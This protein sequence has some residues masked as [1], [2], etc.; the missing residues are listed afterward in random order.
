MTSSSSARLRLAAGVGLLA[1][2]GAAGFVPLVG[3]A[4]ASDEDTAVGAVLSDIVLQASQACVVAGTIPTLDPD[5]AS[6]ADQIVSASFAASGENIQVAR[7]ALMVAWTESTLHDLGPMQGNDG[8]LGLFQQRGW[9]SPQ[10]EMDPA[11]STGLFVQRLLDFSGWPQLPSWVAAQDV[12]RSRF[13]DGR[14][15]RANWA[16]AGQL[17]ERVLAAG[18]QPGSCGQ[19]VPVGATATASAHGLP[20]GYAIP[21]DTGLAHARVV[22]W[23][24]AQLSKPY[25]WGAAGPGAFDCSGLTMA[26]WATVGVPLVHYTATQQAEGVAIAAD[27]L[28]PGDLVLIPGSD[29]PGPGQAGHVGIYLGLGLVESAVDPE[30]GVVVQTWQTFISGGLIALRDPDPADG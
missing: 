21:A 14:N 25:V 3:G 28:M 16:L 20:D 7:I 8:S 11:V 26:A 24:L 15:Y 10:Q 5:Q 29:P 23:A 13:A 6:N 2:L 22:A 18:N 12:Q 4:V 27:Q 19:G 1:A 9:G 30:L 17:L